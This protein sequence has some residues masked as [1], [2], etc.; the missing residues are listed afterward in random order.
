MK[1][2]KM[3]D[4]QIAAIQKKLFFNCEDD[5][6]AIRLFDQILAHYQQLEHETG[7]YEAVVNALAKI[8]DHHKNLTGDYGCY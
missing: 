4:K 2:S 3:S 7:E 8:I 5:Y 1:L 6:A